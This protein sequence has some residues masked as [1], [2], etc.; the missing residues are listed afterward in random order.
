MHQQQAG[1]CGRRIRD[2][3]PELRAQACGHAPLI[4]PGLQDEGVALVEGRACGRTCLGRVLSRGQVAARR[5]ET[6]SARCG[7]GSERDRHGPR[8][9]RPRA[10]APL[11]GGPCRIRSR[12]CCRQRTWRPAGRRRRRAAAALAG[13]RRAVRVQTF[14]RAHTWLRSRCICLFMADW[15]SWRGT[16]CGSRQRWRRPD[17]SSA[18]R[19]QPQSCPVSCACV[20][21]QL[22]A[23][24]C[25]PRSGSRSGRARPPPPASAL[26]N[27]NLQ[28]P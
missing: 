11:R 6:R 19:G 3:A 4:A 8:H 12:R 10:A 15:T 18:Q 7:P 23:H 2:V 17:K 14:L 1:G 27:H 13:G 22:C 20:R 9:G 25:G 5:D 21:L 16:R 24:A 28:Q 26:P